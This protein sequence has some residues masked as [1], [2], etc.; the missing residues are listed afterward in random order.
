MINLE[1]VSDFIHSNFP[2][3][4][5]SANGTHFLARCI[6]CGDSKKSKRKRRFNLDWNGGNPI[7]HC[8]NCGQ[9][10]SFIELYATVKGLSVGEARKDLFNWNRATEYLLFTLS[11]RKREKIIK[12]I[13]HE[14][15]SYILSNC[16]NIHDEY[17]S[18][19]LKSYQDSLKKFIV[20]RG[21]NEGEYDVFLAYDGEYKHRYILPVYDENRMMVYFQARRMYE[22]MILKY[23]NPTLKKGSIII[24][25]KYF[26]R[27]KNII[28]CEGLIDAWTIEYNQGTS[29]L[30]AEIREDFLE[31]IF[32]YT[33]K[34]VIIAL[35]NPALDEQ[36]LLSLRK[37]MVGGHKKRPNKFAKK[38]KYFLF[39]KKYSY[40]KDINNIRKNNKE[41][42]IYEY[43]CANAQSFYKAY[44]RV[45]K[46]G[47]KM[48]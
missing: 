11:K 9:S 3:V 37:F 6:L 45:I 4:S 13:E 8:F 23:K 44:Y 46:L 16:V 24:N 32:E 41:E 34:D 2:F 31:E 43:I 10:G 7:Y 12:E 28:V 35:D 29:A 15:H 17:N 22:D 20:E 47:G 42:N 19:R 48:L 33:D 21:L 14:D 36:G 30:G 25:K 5:T 26:K 38:V 1:F 27:N 40:C 18:L 39:D